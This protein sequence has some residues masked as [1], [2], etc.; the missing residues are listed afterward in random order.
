MNLFCVSPGG[1]RGLLTRL[2]WRDQWVSDIRHNRNGPLIS[3]LDTYL[4]MIG[5]RGVVRQTSRF[6]ELLFMNHCGNVMAGSKKVINYIS[7]HENLK[8]IPLS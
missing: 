3:H 7:G 4:G 1:S 6:R 5:M 8:V 2:Y